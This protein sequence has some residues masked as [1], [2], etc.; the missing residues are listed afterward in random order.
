MRIIN[1]V[2]ARPHF[3]KIAPI[4]KEMDKFEDI[5]HTFLH[6]GFKKSVDSGR[7]E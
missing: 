7:L 2:G 6:T 5:E 4:V 3:M 1:V